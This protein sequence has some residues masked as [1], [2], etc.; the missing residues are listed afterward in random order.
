M[1]IDIDFNNE[2]FLD[3]LQTKCLQTQDDNTHSKAFKKRVLNIGAWIFVLQ[4]KIAKN[5]RRHEHT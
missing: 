3:L 1:N 2:Q 5:R 4:C